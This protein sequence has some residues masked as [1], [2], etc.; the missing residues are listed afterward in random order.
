VLDL[1]IS[2]LDLGLV[3]AGT[4]SGQALS[5]LVTLAQRAEQLGFHRFWIAEHHGSPFV[6][7]TVPPVL[8]ARLAAATSSIRVGSGGVMLP[9][10]SPVVVAE[11]FGT[12]SAFDPGR[13]DLGV[14]RGPGSSN[15]A[16]IEALRQGAPPVTDEDYAAQVRAL[17]GYLT[18]DS[19]RDVRVTM[20]E[21]Y[22]PQVWLLSSSEAG[23]ALAAELGLPLAFA[24]HI[25]P[26]N[27]ESALAVYRDRFTPSRWLDRPQV[28]VSVWAI[29]AETDER[30][31][32]LAR[33]ADIQFVRVMMAHQ[34]GEFLSLQE[35][36]RYRFT[37]EEEDFLAA[38]RDGHLYG[39]PETIRRSITDIVDRLR[40]DELMIQVPVY[41]VDHRTRSLELITK[42]V[43]SPRHQPAC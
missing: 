20:A 26:A 2:V 6:S 4:A 33:P 15:A 14:G 3:Q 21:E 42:H 10:H 16:Y 22:P 36:A 27:S 38:F 9:N 8:V 18:P 17:V 32:E 37:A 11:Q 19:S 12:L 43:V 30:A 29:C 1:P 13:I 41:D 5:Q 31:R 34:E 24:S 39:D 23:A 25:K 35:A 7:S 40:P 28:M